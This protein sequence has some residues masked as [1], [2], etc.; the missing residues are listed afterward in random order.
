M[1]HYVGHR[2]EQTWGEGCA[3]GGVVLRV[4]A[5]FYALLPR[6]QGYRE[7]G[8]S[9]SGFAL[10]RVRARAARRGPMTTTAAA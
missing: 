9:K 10:L 7:V 2:C 4:G 8:S 6:G 5:A 1:R 3:A